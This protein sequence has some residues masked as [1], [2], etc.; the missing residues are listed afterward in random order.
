M[1]KDLVV[2]VLVKVPLGAAELGAAAGS[3]GCLEDS[4]GVAAAAEAGVWPGEEVVVVH[5]FQARVRVRARDGYLAKLRGGLKGYI[6][7]RIVCLQ[8]VSV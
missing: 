2:K 7:W 4:Q 3:L 5:Q 6:S 8:A 1:K